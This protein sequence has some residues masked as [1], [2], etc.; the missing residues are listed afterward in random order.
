MN[1]MTNDDKLKQAL[2][3]MLP[4]KIYT[5]RSLSGWRHYWDGDNAEV[6]DT[7]LLHLCWLAESDLGPD[8]KKKYASDLFDLALAARAGLDE[9][10][11]WY[12]HIHAT[13]QQR[14]TA[15]AKVKGIEI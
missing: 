1:T 4:T 5:R 13:W 11:G 7:E 15:L 9:L 6:Q 14:V 3:K 10:D 12:L 8:L 2:A